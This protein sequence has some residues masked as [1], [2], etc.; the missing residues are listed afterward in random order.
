MRRRRCGEVDGGRG[1]G[2]CEQRLSATGVC[3]PDKRE[4]LAVTAT[5]HTHTSPAS[6]LRFSRVSAH[7]LL[8]LAYAELPRC[9]YCSCLNRTDL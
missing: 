4:L 8:R 3:L 5:H 6:I 7:V 2:A 1:G 9:A